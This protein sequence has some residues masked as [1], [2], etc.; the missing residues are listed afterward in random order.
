MI[1]LPKLTTL[2]ILTKQKNYSFQI[3]VNNKITLPSEIS[4]DDIIEIDN[5]ADASSFEVLGVESK[6]FRSA[7]DENDI[8][9]CNKTLTSLK[10]IRFVIEYKGN[11]THNTTKTAVLKILKSDTA[12]DIHDITLKLTG[13]D[14]TLSL[15]TASKLDLAIH[16]NPVS[17]KLNI[18]T[19]ATIENA[20]ILD[21]T[22]KQV[23]LTNISSNQGIIDT[24][25]IKNGLYI[26]KA[27]VDGKVITK[28]IIKN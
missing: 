23:S 2:Q 7:K 16:P 9:G 28:K 3:K 17:D 8:E 6:N 22:G 26:L 1:R 14:N 21:M 4:K 20:Q 13:L 10:E 18:S 25:S 27:T 15:N 24:S 5:S 12:N 11:Y 19:D